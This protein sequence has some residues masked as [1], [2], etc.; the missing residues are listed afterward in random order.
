MDTTNVVE[1]ASDK[2]DG[3]MLFLGEGNN[4]MILF[5]CLIVL[6]LL[7]DVLGK[8]FILKWISKFAESTKTKWDDAFVQCG[9]FSWLAHLLPGIVIYLGLPFVNISGKFIAYFQSTLNLYILIVMVLTIS[10]F[11][12]TCSV[13]IQEKQ[14]YE[15]IPVRG[16]TQGL[17]ILLFIA[18]LICGLS[19]LMGRSPVFLLGGF[20]AFTAVLMLIFKDPIL[21]LVAGVQLSANRM[22]HLGDWLEMPKYGADGAV[23]DISLTTVKVQNWDK[24]ITT[25]PT[26]ALIS[27][28]FKNWR[29][30]S[31][32]GGR[33]I[34]RAI[35]IDMT[36]IKF[37][38]DETIEKYMKIEILRPYVE[39]S[40]KD[41]I[42]YNKTLGVNEESLVNG[43]H[44]T[45]VGTFRAYLVEFLKAHPM[46]NKDMTFIVRQLAPTSEGLPI[47]IYVFCADKVWANY[48][49][50]QSDI[51]DHVLASVSEFG[52]RVFQSP[53]G[54]DFSKLR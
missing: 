22:L 27:D 24:T 50:I 52:L 15:H 31:E 10:A 49:A 48:E 35:N 47:Q 16:F 18:S 41:V 8:R 6:A 33:R 21:G 51:F 29:G 54:S 17:Q 26:Y 42:E 20:G 38:D 23:F 43:R 7:M 53:T 5:I 34:M 39:R 46:I 19:I 4:G 32:S 3:C 11:L 14:G 28:S 1:L 40:L 44:L 13:V 30:M 45:N 36:S 25:I 2:V 9:V 37:L 12:K